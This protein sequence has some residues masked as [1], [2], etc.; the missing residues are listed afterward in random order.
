MKEASVRPANAGV[1]QFILKF[2]GKKDAAILLSAA[3]L[4]SLFDLIG[5]AVI[6]PYIKIAADP[7]LLLDRVPQVLTWLGS[8]QNR[9][10]V[11]LISIALIVLY[12]CKGFL[13]GMLIR[14]QQR[15]LAV[16]T[17][18]LTDDVV[19]CILTARY[20]LFQEIPGS[21]LASVAYTNT[22]HTTIVFRALIQI[23]NEVCFLAFLGMAFLM[24]SPLPTLIVMLTLAA[25]A[26]LLYFVVLRPTSMLGKQQSSIENE[27]YRLLFSIV[28]AIRDIKVMGLA[29]LFDAKNREVSTQYA[30]IAWRY[31]FNNALPLLVVEIVVAVGLILSAMFVMSGTMQ[32][33]NLM[34]ILGVVALASVRTIPA[35]AKLMAAFNAFR[36]SR[37]FVE[38]LID[39]RNRLLSAKHVRTGDALLLEQRIVLRK[40]CFAYPG[41]PILHDIDLEIERGKFIGIVGISGSG[42]TTLLDLITGLQPASSGEFLCD[43][44]PFNPFQS[45]SLEKMIGYVPQVL[46]LLNES[47]AFNI[48]FEHEPDFEN[49]MRAIK[50]ANLEPLVLSLSD[51]I[52]TRVGENGMNLSGGQRQRI[53]IARALYRRPEILIF[54]EAT[55]ALDAQ[56]EREVSNE[57]VK[58]QGELTL[59]MV[60]H[61]LHAVIN[62]DRIYVLSHG[63][64]Q[65]RGT[66][67]EL[68]GRCELYRD[69]YALQTS[70]A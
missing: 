18:K 52:N 51:G 36:F 28:N 68:L 45:A 64:V 20:G 4:I 3:I 61:R 48:T 54:D 65:D 7:N 10:L 39:I 25:V 55:S 33:G 2:A 56:T 34:P 46:T 31:N 38:R 5:I 50:I 57:I 53:G 63:R 11:M 32:P 13:Q 47:I 30:M 60:S 6:F 37:T 23:G 59:V 15:Q 8:M 35:F 17:A 14:Y 41:K 22:V 24:V 69:L 21:E 67:L 19:S 1:I 42:K 12:L 44:K 58:L 62:C 16:F 27:R 70:L 29:H 43:G 66:H 26:V 49:L 9:Q 40:I